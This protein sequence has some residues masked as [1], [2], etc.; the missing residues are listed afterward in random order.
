MTTLSQIGGVFIDAYNQSV[1][2]DIAGTITTRVD[3]SNMTFI[4]DMNKIPK[5]TS[6]AN[7]EQVFR[8]HTLNEILPY[9]PDEDCFFDS[10]HWVYNTTDGVLPF[11][12]TTR[13][14]AN[15]QQFLKEMKDIRPF[16]TD[17]EGLCRTL[18]AQYYKNG[19]ANFLNKDGGSFAATGVIE[20]DTSIKENKQSLRIPQAT[21]QGYVEVE[22]GSLFDGSYPNSKTRRRRV[23]DNGQSSPTLT[24]NGEPPYY[25]EGTE[26]WKTIIGNKQMNP[27][28]GDVEEISPCITSACGAGGGMTPMLTDAE[29]ETTK[30]KDFIEQVRGHQPMNYRIRKLTPRECFRLMGVSETDIDKIQAAGISNSQQYK[31][32]GNSIVVDVLEHIFR[33][34]FVDRKQET[35]QL[36]MF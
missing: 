22:P 3:A 25:Y 29:L 21:A 12:V 10:R 32:A 5:P 20:K 13:I 31:M 26:E 16:N 23:Q 9:L 17:K 24:A 2:E 8:S 28:R 4:T 6:F 33:K 7:V 27:F 30:T 11:S 14:D 35:Q 18:K 19:A 1:K 15:N 36:W 34:L